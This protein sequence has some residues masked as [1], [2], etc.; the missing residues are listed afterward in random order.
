MPKTRILYLFSVV[1]CL[2]SGCVDGMKMIERCGDGVLDPGEEC[3]GVPLVSC[4]GYH[5]PTGHLR[6]T[7][8]CRLDRSACG[9]RCGDGVIDADFGE[10]CEG[11]D[12]NGGT[13]QDLGYFSGLLSC[14][15]ACVYD[16][17]ACE[18]CGDGVVQDQWGEL[19]DGADPGAVTCADFGGYFGAPACEPTCT[20]ASAGTCRQALQWGSDQSEQALAVALDAEGN[21]YV[22]G[23]TTGILAGTRR[24]GFMDVFLVKVSPR[25]ER[26]WTRQWGS[27]SYSMGFDVAVDVASGEIYVVGETTHSMDGQH[28]VVG[29]TDAFLSKF[30]G[31][32]L[33]LWTRQWGTTSNDTAWGLT[34]DAGGDVY[35]VG[36]TNGGFEGQLNVGESDAFLSRFDGDGQ[37]LWTRQ[38]GSTWYDE[39]RGVAVGPSGDLYVVG[40]A[41]EAVDG[42]AYLGSFDLFLTRY[43]PEGEKRWTRLFGT[44]AQDSGY[45]IKIA[46]DEVIHLI[47]WTKGDLT[48][49]LHEPLDTDLLWVQYD[50][51][52]NLLKTRQWGTGEQDSVGGL[53]IDP[54]GHVFMTGFTRG[55]LTDNSSD[56]ETDVFVTMFEPD[57]T[58][59]WTRQFG[60]PE[61][62]VAKGLAVDAAGNVFLVGTTD[63]DLLGG[64][65]AG[66][67]DLF[68]M[69]IHYVKQASE[70]MPSPS[71]PPKFMLHSQVN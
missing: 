67:G 58:M 60:T 54:G 35:V 29:Q 14:S 52:G 41:G 20:A 32:G 10:Q 69:G 37:I 23:Y 31:D 64:T 24:Y 48:D 56:G 27:R 66:G 9:G 22:T 43:T 30:D 3:D 26:L 44:P 17:S 38:W 18:H 36:D 53:A 71:Q 12:I 39:A 46:P 2:S 34:V 28:H 57:G 62:D 33:L 51:E 47:G 21:L 15:P 61:V 45:G 4:E 8:N 42:E 16:T 55:A 63:G 6:C 1:L 40:F 68:L 49:D 70:W 5:V 25:G 13:C 65:A 11:S 50:S 59:A 19:C 7:A